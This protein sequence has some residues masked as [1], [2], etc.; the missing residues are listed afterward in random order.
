LLLL[1]LAALPAVL[2]AQ[3]FTVTGGMPVRIE[4]IVACSVSA[5]DLDFGAY[6]SNQNEPLRGQSSIELRCAPDTLTEISLDGGTSPGNTRNRKLSHD[7]GRD[8]LDY[9][10][11]Q[12]SA[13]TMHWGDRSGN[14]TLE[15]VTTVPVHTVPVYGE[16]PAG[17]RAQD[18]FY[19]DVITVTV[20]Y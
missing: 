13:R 5:T 7:S 16:I 20:L 8:R 6:A 2:T 15:L 18:G 3:S 10:L 9:D 11:Y 4:I 14:D 12:D 17:Q 19:S 1:A